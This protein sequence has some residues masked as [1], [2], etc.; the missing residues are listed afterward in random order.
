MLNSCLPCCLS[1]GSALLACFL[2]DLVELGS[3]LRALFSGRA[4]GLARDSDSEEEG[5]GELQKCMLK[6][7]DWISL[8]AEPEASPACLFV[9]FCP[10]PLSHFTN[11]GFGRSFHVL[12]TPDAS[13]ISI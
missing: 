11:F 8:K 12:H 7:D 6:L 5:E 13:V 4:S 9:P 3:S 1:K 2:M 10:A